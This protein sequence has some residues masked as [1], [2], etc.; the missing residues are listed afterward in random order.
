[1]FIYTI[2]YGKGRDVNMPKSGTATRDKIIDAAEALVFRHGFSA[3]TVDKVIA[4]AGLTKGAFFYHFK[5]KKDLGRALIRRYSERDLAH[6]ERVM[7]RAEKLSGDPRQQAVIFVGLLREELE[8]LPDPIPGCLFTSYLYER[9]EYPDDVAEIAAQTF[10]RWCERV[11]GKFAQGAAIHPLEDGVTP[12][13]L[14]R[15]LLALIEGGFVLAKAQGNAE[16]LIDLLD[17]FRAQLER[18]FGISMAPAT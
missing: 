6:L 18:Q 14:A 15:S 13:R 12:D 10:Q 17:Q 16:V 1:M 4:E 5:S 11:A 2:Q 9:T 3:T 8:A 7:S